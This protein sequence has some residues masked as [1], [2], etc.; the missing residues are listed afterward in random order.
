MNDTVNMIHDVITTA[1][2]FPYTAKS[3]F[4]GVGHNTTQTN[5][6]L[7]DKK[8]TSIVLSY[9]YIKII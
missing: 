1:N 4:V 7:K 5:Q 2:L 9:M 6:T 8:N 3:M